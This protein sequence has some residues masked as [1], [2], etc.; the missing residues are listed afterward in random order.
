MHFPQLLAPQL[1]P[2][3][4]SPY[5]VLAIGLLLSLAIALAQPVLV[6]VSLLAAAASV[7]AFVSPTVAVYATVLAIPLSGLIRL[8]GGLS[9]ADLAVGLLAAATL[10]QVFVLDRRLT[11]QV[12]LALALGAFLFAGAL[13]LLA[14]ESWQPAA[15]EW[16]KWAEF[17]TLYVLAATVLY[18]RSAAAVAGLVVL[19]G[20]VEAAIGAQQFFSQSGP[21]AFVLGGGF[22]RAFG[23]LGQPNPYAGFLG[24]SLPVAL[25]VGLGAATGFA[26]GRSRSELLLAMLGLGAAGLLASAMIMSWSRGAWVGA[27]ASI[28]CVAALQG[29]KAFLLVAL[30]IGMVVLTLLVGG[31]GALPGPVGGRLSELGG[32]LGRSDPAGA[33]ITDANFSVLERIAHWRAGLEMFDDHPLIGVGLGNYAASYDAYAAPHWYDALGHAHNFGINLLAETG[34]L[35]FL[36]FLAFWLGI[37]ILAL[38][39]RRRLDSWGRA[40]AIGVFGVWVFLTIHSMFD[41][42]FVQHM[43]LQL[44]ALLAALM[45]A[46]GGSFIPGAPGNQKERCSK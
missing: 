41:N 35:G 17:A 5:L 15:Y 44:A 28:A 3:S 43:Q 33:E 31:S 16:L 7:G 2:R 4:L 22:M 42:L 38:R 23:T 24:Y 40:L 29:R 12:P 46:G 30:V 20:L 19:I 8:P 10:A 14:A 45:A 6:A 26:R 21:N 37:P 13:S 18:R 1:Q 32:F 9:L 27:I 34:L 25:A 39:Q 11:L 36:A